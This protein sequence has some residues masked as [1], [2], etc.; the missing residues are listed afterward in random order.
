MNVES[1]SGNTRLLLLPRSE[2]LHSSFRFMPSIEHLP[3]HQPLRRRAHSCHATV[4]LR[5]HPLDFVRREFAQSG[6][7]QRPD[8][9]AAHPVQETVAFNDKLDQPAAMADVASCYPAHGGIP[10]VTPA[11]GEGLEIVPADKQ[12]DAAAQDI[13][14]EFSGHMPG[15]MANQRIHGR[16]V[17]YKIAVLL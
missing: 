9:A 7:D 3:E 6:L 17:P 5:Q 2:I 11:P 10:L 4:F 14:I 12:P 15:G 13:E 1:R 8:D 16:M